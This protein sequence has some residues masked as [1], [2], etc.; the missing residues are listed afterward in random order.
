MQ[1]QQQFITFSLQLGLMGLSYI[2]LCISLSELAIGSL[3]WGGLL[4]MLLRMLLCMLLCIKLRVE[5]HRT[6]IYGSLQCGSGNWEKDKKGLLLMLT[7]I[8]K[9]IFYYTVL[10][11]KVFSFYFYF[12]VL[13]LYTTCVF[14]F[15][16]YGIIKNG[17]KW[18]STLKIKKK[19]PARA[20][21]NSTTWPTVPQEEQKKI[22][23]I[24]Y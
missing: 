11:Q 14:F 4:R 5:L 15:Q 17:A 3:V 24:E 1:Q 16:V 2:L 10:Y 6:P 18:F 23:H 9:Y 13:H 19:L 21:K 12:D 20:E 7:H 22:L 8:W